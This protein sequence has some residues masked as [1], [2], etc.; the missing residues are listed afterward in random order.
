MAGLDMIMIAGDE[1]NFKI[2]T[3]EDLERFRE[4][5]KRRNNN[6]GER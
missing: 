4:L 3:K 1:D 6:T 5:I 2:T